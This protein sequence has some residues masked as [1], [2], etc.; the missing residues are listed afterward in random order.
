MSAIFMTIS[1]FFINIF[2]IF[3]TIVIFEQLISQENW[4]NS[5]LLLDFKNFQ[6][7]YT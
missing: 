4:K 5:P 3:Q 7:K 1:N 2:K 6:L